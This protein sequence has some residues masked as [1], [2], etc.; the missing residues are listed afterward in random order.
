M[1]KGHITTVLLHTEVYKLIFKVWI[2]Q[3]VST[4]NFSQMFADRGK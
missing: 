3:S 1:N 4:V 2:I